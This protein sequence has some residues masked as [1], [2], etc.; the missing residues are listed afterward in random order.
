[1]LVDGHVVLAWAVERRCAAA[2][3]NTYN[4]ET[5]HA[6][7]G[8]AELERAPVFLAAGRGALDHA[9][10]D[11][12]VAA[13][14][15]AAD[16]ASVPVAVHLDHAADLS[17]IR[18]AV[19]AGFTSFMADGSALTFDDDVAL[20]RAA[21]SVVGASLLEAE[22]GGVGGDEDRSGA[23]HTAIPMT[24]PGEAAAL[25]AAT[26]I[27]S[28]AVAIGN[29]HGLYRGEPRLDLAR[30]VAV[31]TAAPVPLVLHGASGI[32]DA[33]LVAC[34]ERG[35]RKVN[36]N[37]ELRRAFHDALATPLAGAA[38][39]GYDLPA[40]FAP[41]VAAVAAVAAGTIRLLR[42]GRR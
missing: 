21:R 35:V 34:V 16:A 36:V 39:A 13:M 15:T 40:L 20:L 33:Q 18:R 1:M 27:D 25:V 24:D 31:A 2:S 30:L 42:D 4:L 10:F 29:A 23:Q 22:L 26:G 9:G 19:E 8:A 7:I 3:F 41:A 6:I 37:T 28:L 14:R 17:L 11:V 38:A 5:T 32:P 12:L